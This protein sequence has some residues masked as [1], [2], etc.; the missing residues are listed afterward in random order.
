MI[1]ILK[2]CLAA[3]QIVIFLG[4]LGIVA[5]VS[6]ANVIAYERELIK[7]GA[8]GG[9]AIWLGLAGFLLIQSMEIRPIILRHLHNKSE[10]FLT[11]AERNL[12]GKEKPLLTHHREEMDIAPQRLQRAIWLSKLFTI[13]D[14]LL[15]VFFLFTP[16]IQPGVSIMTVILTMGIGLIVWRNVLLTVATVWLIPLSVRL[17]IAETDNG[18]PRFSNAVNE[19]KQK[20]RNQ[21]KQPTETAN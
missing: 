19:L 17:A 5:Y 8:P 12:D 11:W 18:F 21:E 16:I 10:E 6:W 20:L 9:I 3:L 4:L 14:L 15:C 2:G 13:V 1:G 7:L